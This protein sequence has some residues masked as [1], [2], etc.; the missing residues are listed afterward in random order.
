MYNLKIKK[1]LKICSC[2]ILLILL[3]FLLNENVPASETSESGLTCIASLEPTDWGIYTG[4]EGDTC[5]YNLDRKGLPGKDNEYHRN[6]NVGVDGTVYENGYEVWLA[7]WNFKEEIS[8]AYITYDL[9]GNYNQLTGKT[10]LINS[11]NTSNFNTTVYFYG[12]GELL[13]SQV[14]TS[15]NYKHEFTVDVSGVNSFK[16]LVQDNVGVKGGTSFALYDMFLSEESRDDELDFGTVATTYK[17]NDGVEVPLSIDWNL[18]SL[19]DIGSVEDESLKLLGILLSKDA[20]HGT[21]S[22]AEHMIQFGL[23]DKKEN[24]LA[25]QDTDTNTGLCFFVS[26][27][28]IEDGDK[29]YYIVTAVSRGTQ[30][31]EIIYDILHSRF[32]KSRG[33]ELYDGI[34]KA[35]EAE[36]LDMKD[37]RV[38]YFLTGHSLGGAVTNYLSNKLRQEGVDIDKIA[39]YTYASPFTCNSWSHTS[40][41]HIYNYIGVKDVVPTVGQAT[42][43]G[44]SANPSNGPLWGTYRFGNDRF[45]RYESKF[46]ETYNN[47]YYPKEWTYDSSI[48]WKDGSTAGNLVNLATSGLIYHDCDTYL[49]QIIA[50]EIYT[51]KSLT[52]TVTVLCPVDVYV[53]DAAGNVVASVIDNTVVNEGNEDVIIAV[54]DDAK[55][56]TLKNEGNYTVKYIGTDTGTMSTTITKKDSTG[57]TVK[58]FSNVALEEDNMK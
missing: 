53:Y 13:H 36:G 54:L 48:G 45:M 12:D 57:E 8:W 27:K 51:D 34:K 37:S 6:G 19:I 41:G 25:W 26:V 40:N 55:F 23:L 4:N 9:G 20:Y 44:L 24:L 52:T 21:D 1:S 38:R 58:T 16:I 33:D 49:A 43:N 31:V 50:G 29:E 5:M 15:S 56:I 2:Y 3:S 18:N 32:F 47:I 39:C 17:A 14:M 11:Y 22:M 7:R 10:S 35:L 42:D 30:G 28:K 46:I